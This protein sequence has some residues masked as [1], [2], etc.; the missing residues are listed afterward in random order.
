MIYQHKKMIFI[1]RLRG[2]D[3]GLARDVA[4]A[5]DHLLRDGHLQGAT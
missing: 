4:L 1:T 5:D 2:G 3:D